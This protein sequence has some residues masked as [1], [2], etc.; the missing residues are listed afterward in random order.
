MADQIQTQV[1]PQAQTQETPAQ[2]Q[3]D[4][5]SEAQSKRFKAEMPQIPGVIPGGPARKEAPPTPAVPL[6]VGIAAI[7]LVALLG[8]RLVSHPK[9]AEQAVAAPPP[10]IEV[11]APAVDPN[12]LLP[13]DSAAAPAR[14]TQFPAAARKRRRSRS[15]FGERNVQAMDQQELLLR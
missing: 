3:P 12:S 9:P 10:Q 1:Q 15:R 6:G 13:H 7:V 8:A 2:V 11:P 5:S 4:A 14:R